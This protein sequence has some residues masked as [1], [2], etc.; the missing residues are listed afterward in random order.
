MASNLIL[1]EWNLTES[2]K[3]GKWYFLWAF[4]FGWKVTRDAIRITVEVQNNSKIQK[5]QS[6]PS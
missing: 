2:Y 5:A 3:S 1:W 6:I 4:V